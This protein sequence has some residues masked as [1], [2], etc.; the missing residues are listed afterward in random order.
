MYLDGEVY[1]DSSIE[2]SM[3]DILFDPQTSGGLLIAAPEK[4]GVRLLRELK[5]M[6]PTAEI[7]GW[8]EKKKEH[9]IIIK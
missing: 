9:R 2:L 1:V 5:N 7:I 6:I 4:E 3:E 8:V